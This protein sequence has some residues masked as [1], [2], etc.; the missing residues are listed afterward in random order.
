MGSQGKRRGR[1]TRSD[2]GGG[3]TDPTRISLGQAFRYNP[4]TPAGT[5][6][7]LG[8]LRRRQPGE[9]RP[10][11][12]QT[13]PYIVLGGLVFAGIVVVLRLLPHFI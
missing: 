3:H 9:P 7:R 5:I 8:A 11:I 10:D 1:R 2:E 6:E 13:L 4:Y 12:R